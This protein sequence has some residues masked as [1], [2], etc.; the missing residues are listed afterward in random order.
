MLEGRGRPQANPSRVLH[1]VPLL[2]RLGTAQVVTLALEHMFNIS[3]SAAGLKSAYRLHLH[4][5]YC[6]DFY[7]SLAYST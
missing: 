2:H 7:D 5:R 6:F 1:A 3:F 4:V